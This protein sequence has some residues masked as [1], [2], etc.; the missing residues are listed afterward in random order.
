MHQDGHQLTVEGKDCQQ[1]LQEKLIINCLFV[2]ATAF[3]FTSLFHA[4][5]QMTQRPPKREGKRRLASLGPLVVRI[6]S[7]AVSCKALGFNPDVDCACHRRKE[8]E[9]LT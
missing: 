2:V 5:E 8:A 3:V 4:G 7:P 6:A 9:K 1:I